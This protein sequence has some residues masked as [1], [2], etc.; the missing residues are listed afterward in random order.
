MTSLIYLASPYSHPDPRVCRARVQLSRQVAAHIQRRQPTSAVFSPLVWSVDLGGDSI[1]NVDWYALTMRFL[2]AADQMYIIRAPG[3]EASKGVC[4]EVDWWNSKPRLLSPAWSCEQY[5]S[6][7]PS[8]D[9]S[10]RRRMY[11]Y[12]VAGFG[13]P[14]FVNLDWP[15]DVP[16]VPAVQPGI[17]GESAPDPAITGAG[18]G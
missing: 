4:A 14:F 2:E 15:L 12:C 6:V 11:P 9:P 1:P 5:L 17:A 16:A 8:F 3:W 18:S 13:A 7:T 10:E